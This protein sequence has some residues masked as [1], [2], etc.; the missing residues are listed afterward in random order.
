MDVHLYTLEVLTQFIITALGTVSESGTIVFY[1]IMNYSGLIVELLK[2]QNQILRD[3]GLDKN[4]GPEEFTR[5]ILNKFAKL[6]SAIREAFKIKN[7]YIILGHQNITN[8]NIVLSSGAVVKPGELVYLN[9]PANH[10]DPS[11]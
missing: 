5:E 8:E 9:M 7:F 4:C 2:E 10:N 1:R 6:D 11:L 3:E